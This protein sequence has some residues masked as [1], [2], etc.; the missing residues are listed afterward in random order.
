MSCPTVASVKEFMSAIWQVP[1]RSHTRERVYRGQGE[2]WSLLPKLF[3]DGDENI[4]RQREQFLKL[5]F[6]NRSLFLLPSQPT[7]QYDV[8]S[9]AQHYGLPTRLLDWSGNPLMALFF[10]VDGCNPKCPVVI[11]FDAHHEQVIAGRLLN[12]DAFIHDQDKTILLQPALHS[13]RVVAQAGWHTVHS[14][15]RGDGKGLRSMNETDA[16]RLT[17][18]LIAAHAAVGIKKELRAMGIH[19]A[20]VYG[21]LASVCREIEDDL[22]IPPSMRRDK[23]SDYFD[24]KGQRYEPIPGQ[25]CRKCGAQLSVSA[26]QVN[27]LW[28]SVSGDAPLVEVTCPKCGAQN[29]SILMRPI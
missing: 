23:S 2:N 3:R 9:L 10:A 16:N 5:A 7:E 28:E 15:D 4:I 20:T 22:G 26:S 13:Q 11:I 29:P 25:V 19:A 27:E 12:K 14:V 24:F 17:T 18:I 8:L 1:P 6:D 21:D